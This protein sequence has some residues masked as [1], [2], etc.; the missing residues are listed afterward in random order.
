MENRS[1]AMYFQVPTAVPNWVSFSSVV[2][3]AIPKST[4]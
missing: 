2:A 3:L 1:G 4:R